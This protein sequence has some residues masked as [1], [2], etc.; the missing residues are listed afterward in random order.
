LLCKP[1]VSRKIENFALC[2]VFFHLPQAEKEAAE[3]TYFLSAA[4][5]PKGPIK[6]KVLSRAEKK[7]VEGQTYCEVFSLFKESFILSPST[8]F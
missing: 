1:S 8:T 7:Q 6:R 2:R 5:G 3:Q 4:R